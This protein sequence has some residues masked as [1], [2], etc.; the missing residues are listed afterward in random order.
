MGKRGPKAPAPTKPLSDAEFKQLVGM[1][2]IQ[3]TRDEI[4][5]VFGMGEK[6][7]N[8]RLKERGEKNF[9]ALY[10]KHQSEGNSSM[11]RM[12]WKSAQSGSVPMQIWLGKQVLGQRDKADVDNTSSDGTMKPTVIELVGVPVPDEQSKD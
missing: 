12:Q 1:I 10:K 8:R 3:C 2:Q 11:R 6:T 5:G 9:D 7:L 4:C